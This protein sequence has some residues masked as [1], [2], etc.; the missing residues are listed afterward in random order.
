MKEISRLV[1][2][3]DLIMIED[4][5]HSIGATFDGKKVGS[6]GDAGCF[7][8]YATKNITTG[9]GG[10]IVTDNGELKNRTLP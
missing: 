1:R 9:E 7:S 10:M 3:H 4:C 2:E 5:A 8:F 6:F